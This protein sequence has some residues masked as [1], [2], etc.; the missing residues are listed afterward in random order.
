MRKKSVLPEFSV[1][2]S[3]DKR[4]I[5][6]ISL[7]NIDANKTQDII[8]NINGAKYTSVSGRIITSK[9]VQDYNSFDEPNRIHPG[10]FTDVKGSGSSL[11]V[12]LPP[13]SVVMLALN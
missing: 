1:S 2:A 10:N 6:H 7:V 12:K 13:F 9:K 4:G 8:I 11:Q 3:K 5:T